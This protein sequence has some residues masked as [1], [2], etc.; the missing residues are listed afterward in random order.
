[1]A[2]WINTF[3]GDLCTSVSISFNSKL[4]K[5]ILI[6]TSDVLDG[7]ILNHTLVENKNLKGQF[8][9]TF[10]KG[11]I[12]YSEIRPANKRF[13]YVDIE[14]TSL[15]IASTK[16]MVLRPNKNIIEPRFL[17]SILKSQSIVNELQHLAETRSGTFPQITFI[18]ELAPMEVKIPDRITQKQIIS[19]LET[20]ESLIQTNITINDNLE[21]QAQAIFKKNFIECIE[22][23]IVTLSDYCSFVKGKNPKLVADYF[24]KDYELYLNIDTLTNN[25]ISYTTPDCLIKAGEKDILMVMDGASSGTVY[26]GKNG[27]VGSTIAKIV[28]LDDNMREIIYQA[29][30]YYENDIKNHTTGSAI[31]H[32]DKQYVLQLK[33]SLPKNYHM[34]STYFEKIRELI[35]SNRNK[36]NILKSLRDTLLPKLMSGEI[37]VSNI[38]V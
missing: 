12:L 21:Q 4:S 22:K 30:K 15:Y 19:I 20:I 28:T 24:K 9:K 27:V 8:K 17:F 32:T 11:D 29:L 5:V 16:L 7:N 34:F 33:I 3:I 10:K 14:D 36:N 38:K 6:N 31:P 13:A 25:K 37:D 2:K 18:S 35:I 26:F 23:D 1:M